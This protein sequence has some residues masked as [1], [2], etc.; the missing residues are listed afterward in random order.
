MARAIAVALP[1]SPA[2]RLAGSQVSVQ[3]PLLLRAG[4]LCALH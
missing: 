2:R 1:A 3:W 4:Q